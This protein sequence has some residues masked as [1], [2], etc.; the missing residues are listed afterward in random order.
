MN[1][2]VTN[3]WSEFHKELKSFVF[4]KT[5]N[6]AD[7]DD[8]LQ[9]VFIKIIR[10]IS[11]VNHSENLRQYIYGIVRNTVNNYFR[12]Q[13]KTAADSEIPDLLSEPEIQTLNATVAECCI[14]PFINKLPGKYKDALLVTEFQ[15]ISQKELAKKLNISYSGL[16]SRVQRG[17]EK[18][19]EL[20]LSC[21]AY[22]VDSYGNLIDEN[23]KNCN[24][25]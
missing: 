2:N 7:T 19:K 25:S 11:K 18:L 10:N 23:E 24:C 9:E 1:N 17:K 13:K 4:N 8:I 5:R 20:I 16:K 15:N 22:E 14:R 3:I 6:S 21:C 12:N